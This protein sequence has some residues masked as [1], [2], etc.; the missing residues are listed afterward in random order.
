MLLEPIISLPLALIAPFVLWPIELLLPYPFILEEIAKTLIIIPLLSSHKNKVLLYGVGIG[1]LFTLSE[2]ILYALNT[3]Y[4]SSHYLAT[5]LLATGALHVTTTLII[6]SS[7]FY[8][9][10]YLLAGL[11]GAI[12]VHYLYNSFI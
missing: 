10:R 12:I 2:T 3:V 9:K 1:I 11:M 4:G 6:L 5:R 8:K 7:G